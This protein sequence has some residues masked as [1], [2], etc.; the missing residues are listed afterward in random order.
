[1]REKICIATDIF[2]LVLSYHCWWICSK[3]SLRVRRFKSERYEIW[4]D[5][6]S[7]KFLAGL[8]LCHRERHAKNF[9]V[10]HVPPS[11]P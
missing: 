11:T 8:R 5:C 1:M 3:K 6:S 4:Q 7:G 2:L 9:W 10:G